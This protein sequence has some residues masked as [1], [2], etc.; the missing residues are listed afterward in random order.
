MNRAYLAVILS[1]CAL[2]GHA[3]TPRQFAERFYRGCSRWQIRGVPTPTERARISRFF[4][5]EIL[6]LYAAAERQRTEFE[7]RFPFDPKH[8]ELALKPPWCKEG[9]PFSATD[10]G[11][12]TFAIGR[13]TRIGKQVAVQAHLEYTVGGK[14]YPWTD[15]LVLDRASGEWVVSDIRFARGGTLVDGMRAGVTET[16]TEL[17]TTRK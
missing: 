15:T 9:D 3:E 13:V 5:A 11:A 7:R 10:E 6:H 1:T 12:S 4:S 16:E 2:Q 14:S 8:P 17:R